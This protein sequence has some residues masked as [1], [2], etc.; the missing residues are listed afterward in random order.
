MSKFAATLQ[1]YAFPNVKKAI[2]V[3][4]WDNAEGVSIGVAG[5]GL[6]TMEDDFNDVIVIEVKE[7]RPRLLVWADINQEDPTHIIDL[8]G[9]SIRFRDKWPAGNSTKEYRHPKANTLVDLHTG[10]EQT[11]D[12]K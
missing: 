1:D 3:A 7:G 6:A 9:A 5:L 11:A 8:Q 10:Q 4:L 2:T 12:G